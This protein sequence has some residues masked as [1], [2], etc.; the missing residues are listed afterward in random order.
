[1]NITSA[2]R[3]CTFLCAHLNPAAFLMHSLSSTSIVIYLD[4]FILLFRSFQVA[5]R[6]IP[7]IV[8]CSPQPP[9]SW[10]WLWFC[11]SRAQPA[12]NLWRL[13][14]LWSSRSHSF[15]PLG[16]NSCNCKWRIYDQWSQLPRYRVGI[17]P[18]CPFRVE[19]IYL[20]LEDSSNLHA[21]HGGILA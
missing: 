18:V 20:W 6:I 19:S 10:S 5:A 16:A 11:W 8:Q 14:C 2:W 17:C 13:E 15:P 21:I 9:M 7:S 1:M 12:Q 4:C 3:S